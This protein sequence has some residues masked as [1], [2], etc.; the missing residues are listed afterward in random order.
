MKRAKSHTNAQPVTCLACPLVE[1]ALLCLWQLCSGVCNP[2]PLHTAS[3][4]GTSAQDYKT[5][6]DAAMSADTF[7]TTLRCAG[8]LTWLE[9]YASQRGPRASGTAV[10]GTGRS[11]SSSWRVHGAGYVTTLNTRCSAFT[12]NAITCSTN[13]VVQSQEHTQMISLLAV[14]HPLHC[15]TDGRGDVKVFLSF[16]LAVMH[17]R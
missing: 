10:P 15:S 9:A 5:G 3:A 16:Q 4:Q 11:P 6:Q 7:T 8:R 1:N 14:R 12:S 17:L 2:P 13:S